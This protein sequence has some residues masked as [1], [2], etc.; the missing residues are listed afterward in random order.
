MT[1]PTTWLDGVA[2]PHGGQPVLSAGASVDE[3]SAAVIMLHGRGA[4]ANGMIELAE[5]LAAPGVAFLAPQAAGNTWYPYRFLEP[6]NMNEP[7]VSGA[8]AVVARLVARLNTVGI[9]AE[10]V[11]LLGFSQ[12]A[13]LAT[14]I[15]A[16][17]SFTRGGVIGLSGGL[18]GDHIDPSEY[19]SELN[20]VPVFLGCSDIDPHIPV[21]RVHETA[22]LLEQRGADVTTTI[23]PGMGHTINQDEID[24]ARRIISSMVGG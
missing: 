19:E 7:Q 21:E 13:C 22:S 20:G 8:I 4:T 6:R 14:D 17:L 24:H 18:I 1:D 9:P 10:R 15:A 3:A 12:G 11:A 5:L 16:R 2:A 23:Y